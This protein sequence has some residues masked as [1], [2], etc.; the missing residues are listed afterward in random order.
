VS[1]FARYFMQDQQ[2]T[3]DNP[4]AFVPNDINET[5]VGAEYRAYDFTLTADHVWHDSSLDP[6]EASHFSARFSRR[7]RTDTTIAASV[8]YSL[9][10]YQSS[11][12]NEI[13]LITAAADVE[14]R[15]S[16]RLRGRV[17]FLYRDEDDSV[18]GH[19]QGIEETVELRWKHRQTELFIMFRNANYRTDVQDRDFQFLQVGVRRD[20]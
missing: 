2:V 14:H 20:F 4:E 15:F 11:Q 18:L 13:A 19:T 3:T 9:I 8:A 5:T 16:Q 7:F 17:S 12:Q 6:Y 10:E 1:L